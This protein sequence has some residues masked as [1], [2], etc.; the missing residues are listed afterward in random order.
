[1]GESGKPPEDQKPD[2]NPGMFGTINS[3]GKAI[4]T[5]LPP[6]FAMMA[7]LNIVFLG[8]VLW[9]LS[10]GSD[11]RVQIVGDLLKECMQRVSK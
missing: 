6:A 4:I 3:L 11:T 1:M 9:F 7:V 8:V 5:T 10:A 2:A